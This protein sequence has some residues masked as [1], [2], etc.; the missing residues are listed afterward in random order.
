MKKQKQ[1]NRIAFIGRYNEEEQISGPEKT[2][3]RIFERSAEKYVPTFYQYFFDGYKYGL[4]EKLFGYETA[5]DGSG[6]KICITGIVRL[7]FALIWLKPRIIH[8][9]TFERFAVAAV[10]YAMLWRVKVI[11][12]CHGIITYE[13]NSIKKEKAFYRFKNR[14]SEKLFL[15]KAWKIV[16]PSESAILICERYYSIDESK[17]L[18]IPNGI[19]DTFH[20]I[21][22][23][24]SRNG[25]VMLSGNELHESRREFLKKF[26]KDGDHNIQLYVIGDKNYFSDIEAAGVYFFNSMYSSELADFYKNKDIFLSLNNYDTF[27]ISAVESM[28]SGLIPIVTKQTGMSGLIY[29]DVNGFVIEY[30]DVKQL[31]SCIHKLLTMNSI[32]KETIRNNAK[33]IYYK[34][35]W[36]NIFAQYESIYLAANK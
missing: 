9:I 29:N 11:Y 34:L 5:F 28:A 7:F 35:N 18:I 33:S 21:A 20:K 13:D 19:D 2:A 14:Y 3:K 16:F 4:F 25:I 30:G 1:N 10:Y 32:E 6:R 27:S 15:K 12:N 8:I 17:I 23:S 36:E 24:G 31:K 22:S 26:L